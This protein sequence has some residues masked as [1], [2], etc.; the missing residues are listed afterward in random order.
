MFTGIIE[1]IGI[2]KEIKEEG[3]NLHFKVVSDIC[4]ELKIDQSLSH[5]GV[6]LTVVKVDSDGHWVTAVKE[7]LDKSSLGNMEV[8]TEVNLERAMKA[9]ERFDGHIVQGH[10]D[11][12]AKVVNVTREDGS[13]VYRFSHEKTNFVL[14]EK[15]SVCIN[16]VSLTCFNVE[17]NGF[18]V[19]II[20]F[21]FSHT[22]FKNLKKDDIVNI[23]FDIL[24]KYIARILNK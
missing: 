15:G 20:P 11:T 5:D 18:E 19:T 9:N 16:G 8:G 7:T 12:I 14:V 22:N 13:W 17:D 4:S 2:I 24:G 23:E 21:T 3:T 10:V 1:S 6:C